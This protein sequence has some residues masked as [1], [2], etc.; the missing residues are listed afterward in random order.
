MQRCSYTI[1]PGGWR[2]HASLNWRGKCLFLIRFT[3][4]LRSWWLTSPRHWGD[5][6]F[7]KLVY[8]LVCHLR[9]SEDNNDPLTRLHW[10]LPLH[11]WTQ[12]CSKGVGQCVL[13]FSRHG[14]VKLI[15]GS[16]A[17]IITGQYFIAWY[18]VLFCTLLC[19][20]IITLYNLAFHFTTLHI[21]G[22]KLFQD[23]HGLVSSVLK[24]YFSYYPTMWGRGYIEGL[25]NALCRCYVCVKHLLLIGFVSALYVAHPRHQFQAAKLLKGKKAEQSLWEKH[26]LNLLQH[27]RTLRHDRLICISYFSNVPAAFPRRFHPSRSFPLA[28]VSLSWP[29]LLRLSPLRQQMLRLCPDV[30]S[31]LL[32]NHVFPK[33]SYSKHLQRCLLS[34]AATDMPRG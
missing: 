30:L 22:S 17:I 19:P 29:R 28:S 31:L 4:S 7:M 27:D 11:R 24:C 15:P 20:L 12:E 18:P 13:W 14:G 16:T 34:S 25:V 1:R 8:P 33:F 3:D 23:F 10:R 32:S 9:H 26:A 5:L 21:S 2:G 6:L